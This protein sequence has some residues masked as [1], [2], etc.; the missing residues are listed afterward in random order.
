MAE[1]ITSPEVLR[2]LRAITALEHVHTPEARAVIE[3]LT[4]GAPDAITTREAK[5][6]LERLNR[7]MGR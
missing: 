6:T 5:A 4:Q 2:S 1:T 3:R 7:A